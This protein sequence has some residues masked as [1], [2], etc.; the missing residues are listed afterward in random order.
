MI[1]GSVGAAPISS[2]PIAGDNFNNIFG[3]FYGGQ[4]FYVNST[5]I[6]NVLDDGTVF[7]Y[8]NSDQL[9]SLEDTGT[10]ID[11]IDSN[12]VLEE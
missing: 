8:A 12:T 7:N 9:F 11:L 4:F 3:N 10:I 6:F 1:G 2:L 5:T